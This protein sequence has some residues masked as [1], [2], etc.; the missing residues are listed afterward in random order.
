MTV[1]FSDYVGFEGMALFV[2]PTKEGSAC[3]GM[4]VLF[5]DYVDFEGMTLFVLPDEGRICLRRNDDKS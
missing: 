2:I 3:A 1:L 5:S 4:T